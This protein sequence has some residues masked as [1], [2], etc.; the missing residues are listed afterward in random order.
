MSPTHN[1]NDVVFKAK[2]QYCIIFIYLYI[3]FLV[4]QDIP[5]RHFKTCRCVAEINK[6]ITTVN[7]DVLLDMQKAVEVAKRI[8]PRNISVFMYTLQLMSLCNNDAS[9]K[10]KKNR[11]GHLHNCCILFWE[12]LESKLGVQPERL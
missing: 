6:N 5:C 2:T 1:H 7:R 12:S 3:F 11:R 8:F 4:L 9:Q 10:K